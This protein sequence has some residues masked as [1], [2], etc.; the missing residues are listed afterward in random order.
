[1]M[2]SRHDPERIG[3]PVKARV[4]SEY[5]RRVEAVRAEWDAWLRQCRL[6]SWGDAAL[7]LGM[8]KQGISS[9]RYR[10]HI[11]QRTRLAMSAVLAGL[12]PYGRE[13]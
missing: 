6:R 4:N 9:A 13:Q 8:T 11:D 10:E 5:A 7:A 3:G 1:M 12:D 2:V